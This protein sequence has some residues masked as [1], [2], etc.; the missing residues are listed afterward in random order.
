MSGI[1]GAALNNGAPSPIDI[2]ITGAS[3]RKLNSIATRIR[4][5]A[6]RVPGAR[7]VRIDE[8]ISH[9]EIELNI[10][11]TKA[12]M[13]GVTADGIIKNVE[14]ALNSSS[15]FNSRLYWVDP[16]SGNDYF[17]GVTYPQFRLDDVEALD[18]VTIST[19]KKLKQDIM[20][21]DVAK[22]S[23][24]SQPI[25]IKHENV[26]RTFDVFAN[27]EGRDIGS[28][29]ADIENV[30]KPVTDSIPLGYTIKAK[31][32]IK[33]M[34]DAFSSLGFGLILAI[35]IV[36]LVI[37]PL[38]KS[39]K[40]PLIIILV[41]PLGMIGVIFMLFFTNTNLNIQS[42]MGIIMM[43]GITV[44]YSNLLVDKMNNLLREGNPLETAIMEGI[45]NRFRPILMTAIVAI[46]ALFPMA[47][48]YEIGGEANIPLAR[49]I[50]GGVIAATVLSLFVVPVI[51]YFF[52]QKALRL[53]AEDN[54]LTKKHF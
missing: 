13:V 4:D 1:V 50:I 20:L 5:L 3:F 14:S 42:F 33:S 54:N 2:Q 39:F 22:V 40:L 53:P 41:V 27:V 8:R 31:G 26:Q 37:V 25:E 29:D 32:E 34:H 35:V 49:A 44:A 9:P 16:V 6:R 43:V 17:L 38:L 12:A 19:N 47:L 46:F 28:V 24:G 52:N 30:I 15:T 18:N 23:I 21:K 10:N 7:D 51:F 36:Y 45:T 11:R 48:G